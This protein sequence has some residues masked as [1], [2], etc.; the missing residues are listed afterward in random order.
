MAVIY[1]VCGDRLRRLSNTPTAPMHRGTLL[2]ERKF[3]LS[4][5]NL[6]G[7]RLEGFYPLCLEIHSHTRPLN[8]TG[9]VFPDLFK[10]YKCTKWSALR[11]WFI[12]KAEWA[13][14]MN[15]LGMHFTSSKVNLQMLCFRVQMVIKVTP[16]NTLLSKD[17]WF[18]LLWKLGSC[19]F[20]SLMYCH[21]FF[22]VLWQYKDKNN[23]A[24]TRE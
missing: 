4:R 13:P 14:V 8:V 12:A 23:F 2:L 10:L 20:I 7:I 1:A 24:S 15:Y 18:D 17:L 3:W 9:L 16:Y 21:L 5:W 6:L 11:L 19:E 22:F